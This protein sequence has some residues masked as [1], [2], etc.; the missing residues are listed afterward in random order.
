MHELSFDEVRDMHLEMLLKVHNFCESNNIRYFLDAG[1]LLG[2][3]RHGGFI[4]W[5]DDVDICMPRC[6]YDR[7][8]QIAADGFGDT[9]ELLRPE[10]NIYPILK[11][12]DRRT[13]LIEFPKTHKNRIG[14]YID[15]FPKDGIP[16]LSAG[17]KIRCLLVRHLRRLYWFNKLSIYSWKNDIKWT[18]KSI[19][20][21][22]RMI[23][24]NWFRYLPLKLID[25]LAK[26]YPF[27]KSPFVATIVAGG[28]KNC[29]SRSCFDEAVLHRFENLMLRVPIGYDE[30]LKKL[31]GDYLTLPPEEKRKMHDNLA[32]MI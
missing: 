16:A 15:V 12:I 10:Q 32:Y 26:K 7:F 14:V 25:K 22:G 11:I 13:L 31:Y 8:M 28:L 19:A 23:M 27:D 18:K 24:N 17:S 1:T 3:I 29:V 21:I 2:S 6:D 5:D 20:F 30:Y 9:L 4:P